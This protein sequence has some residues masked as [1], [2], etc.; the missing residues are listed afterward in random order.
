[1]GA[2]HRLPA[3][4]RLSIFRFDSREIRALRHTIMHRHTHPA[5]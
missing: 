3:L 1:L 4:F 2:K 5:V